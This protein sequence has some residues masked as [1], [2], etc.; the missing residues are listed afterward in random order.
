M[1]TFEL[2]V[3]NGVFVP[4]YVILDLQHRD[5]LD[6]QLLVIATSCKPPVLFTHG[7]RGPIKVRKLVLTVTIQKTTI[8]D[9]IEKMFLVS[10]HPKDVI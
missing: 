3:R 4:I 10:E 9:A 6:D 1:W 7:R 5:R 2:A 8:L